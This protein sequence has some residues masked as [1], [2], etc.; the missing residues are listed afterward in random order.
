MFK[1]L[2]VDDEEWNRDIIKNLGRW[3]ELGMEVAGEAE[4]GLEALRLIEQ[5]GPE[6]IITDMRMP[7][8]DGE[9]LMRN[10]HDRFPG[11]QVIVVSGYDD[12]HYARQAIRY[13]AADYLLKPIDPQELNAV[14]AKC[15]EALRQRGGRQEIDL[16]LS[17]KLAVYKKRLGSCFNELNGEGIRKV[18]GELHADTQLASALKPE[19]IRYF[20]HEIL[21]YL[22]ELCAA[23][24]LAA[25]LGRLTEHAEV[26]DSYHDAAGLME[27]CYMAALDELIKQ[28]KFKNKLHLG[29]VKSYLEHHFAEPVGLEQL[30]K[31][32]FVSKEYLSKVFKQEY[33]ITVTDY[34]LQLRM[35][36][37]MEWLG[38]GEEVAIKRVAEMVGYEDVSYFHRVFKKHF[39]LSPGEAR[40]ASQGLKISNEGV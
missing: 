23:N 40:K 6:L 17:A 24:A 4:D 38:A 18:F 33:G 19:T 26:P 3:D 30:A 5:L 1:V 20:V 29:E 14:L 10:I 8:S 28:R 9:E 35:E 13:K 11:K 32:F 7:G 37:A 34:L 2:I 15:R 27:G 21:L 25:E 31:L 39:G 16:E 22:K 36:K 12:F